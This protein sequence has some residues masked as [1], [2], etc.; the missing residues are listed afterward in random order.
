MLAVLADKTKGNLSTQETKLLDSALF[1]LRM[2]LPRDHP[3]PRPLRRRPGRPTPR[4]RPAQARPR[5]LAHGGNPHLSRQRHLHGRAHPRL[6]LRRLHLHRP[7]Q[8]PHPP[9]RLARLQQPHSSSSTPAPTSTRRPSASASA[10]VDAVLY[11]H[12]HADHILGFDDLRPLSFRHPVALPLYADDET[13]TTIERI[14]EYTFRTENRYP[15]S[16]RVKLHR[17]DPAAG[18]GI[19][20][21]GACFQRIPVLHGKQIIT[22]YRF[23]SAAYLTDMSDIPPESLPLLQDLDILILDA[24]RRTPTPAT[25]TSIA[26]SPSSSSSSPGAPSSPT[27]ATTSTTA[28]PR[29]LSPPTSASPTTASSSSSKSPPSIIRRFPANQDCHPEHSAADSKDLRSPRS[30]PPPDLPYSPMHIY[31]HLDE[32]PATPTPAVAT[33]GNFDGVHRGH[34]WVIDNVLAR[35]RAAGLRSLVITF[36]PH[37]ARAIRPDQSPRTHHSL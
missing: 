13:A 1:E 29:P 22:G 30:E 35:A 23:G 19:E 32:L 21:F 5:R 8:P 20:L 26:P 14:F 2:A 25:P 33:I 10:Q 4:W 7:S 28:P 17:I 6:R 18:A 9:L 12:R 37:P 34:R 36:D 31:R 3:G 24:L 27:S 11:T 16:A 15:T